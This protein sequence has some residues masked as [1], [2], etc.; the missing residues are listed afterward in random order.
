MRISILHIYLHIVQLMPITPLAY[1]SSLILNGPRREWSCPFFQ[2]FC[3]IANVWS[4][5]EPLEFM[6]LLKKFKVTREVFVFFFNLRD[7]M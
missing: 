5:V 1:S 3:S 2:S 4:R 7:L 6:L